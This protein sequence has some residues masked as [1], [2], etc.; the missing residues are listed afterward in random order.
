MQL[1]LAMAAIIRDLGQDGTRFE[2]VEHACHLREDFH[3]FAT[4]DR[5]ELLLAGQ[6]L[7]P[8]VAKQ[9]VS[10]EWARPERHWLS[11]TA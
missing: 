5:P 11:G 10:S 6:R 7:G 1:P 9:R 4:G 2:I 8:S 3:R